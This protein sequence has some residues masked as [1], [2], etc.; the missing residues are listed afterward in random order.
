MFFLRELLE[1]VQP[2][3]VS[4]SGFGSIFIGE[5]GIK[6]MPLGQ[7]CQNRHE[8]EFDPLLELLYIVS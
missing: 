2:A 1:N 7:V 3:G 4:R 6:L 5:G 8:Q